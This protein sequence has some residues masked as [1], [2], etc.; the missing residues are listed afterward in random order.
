MKKWPDTYD[1]PDGMSDYWYIEIT[2]M[3]EDIE[4][5]CPDAFDDYSKCCR[6]G[7]MFLHSPGDV[8]EDC[9]HDNHYCLRLGCDPPEEISNLVQ[10]VVCD[11]FQCLKCARKC[12]KENCEAFT[13]RYSEDCRDQCYDEH[14]D[15]CDEMKEREKSLLMEIEQKE[16]ELENLKSLLK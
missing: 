12:P 8:C 4:S 5:R 16:K 13:C 3:L 1:T 14:I 15:Q 11:D 7:I 2:C 6:C 10:C 9:P